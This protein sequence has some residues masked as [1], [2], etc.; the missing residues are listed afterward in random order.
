MYKGQ[1][2]IT[3]LQKI[4]NGDEIIY[5]PP[6][7]CNH[8]HSPPKD[9]ME[10]QEQFLHLPHPRQRALKGQKYKILNNFFNDIKVAGI[11]EG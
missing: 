2:T 8:D 9:R 7:M 4:C 5:K 3:E 1:G 11:L 6:H 10:P